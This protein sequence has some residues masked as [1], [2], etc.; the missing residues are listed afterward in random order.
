METGK[1]EL[2]SG[3]VAAASPRTENVRRVVSPQTNVAPLTQ[4]PRWGH[5]NF[6]SFGFVVIRAT[7][8]REPGPGRSF[9]PS[10]MTA[11]PTSTPAARGPPVAPQRALLLTYAKRLP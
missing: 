8:D 2:N 5:D 4:L 11:T 1:S 7:V 3:H 6:R 10:T 9:G